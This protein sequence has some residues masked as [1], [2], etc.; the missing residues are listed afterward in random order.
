M[1]CLYLCFLRV[2]VAS[3]W[4]VGRQRVKG[5][6]KDEQVITAIIQAKNTVG[7]TGGLIAGVA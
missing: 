6:E 5:P 1:I 4:R 3:G 7:W 2:T